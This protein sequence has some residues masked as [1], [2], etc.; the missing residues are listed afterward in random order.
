MSSSE[1]VAPG[2]RIGDYRIEGERRVEETGVI[3]DATHLVLPR[4][5]AIKVALGKSAAVQMLRE[6]CVLEALSHPGVPRV[7]ECGVLPDKRP[8]VALEAIDGASLATATKDTPIAIADLAMVMRACADILAHAHARGVVHHRLDE[9]IVILTPN[10]TSPVCVRGWGHVVAH[11]SQHAADPSSDIL[12]LGA[13][14]YR[15]LLRTPVGPG[16]SAQ[17][18][19]PEAPAD[20]TK[21]IDEMLAADP[22]RRPTAADVSERAEWIAE[23]ME[24]PR[25]R[26]STPTAGM[27]PLKRS[28]TPDVVVR[29]RG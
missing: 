1:R 8:W 18:S 2:T 19:C 15:A 29:I 11:D 6:A 27:Q 24:A 20:L 10:R 23:T 26:V 28:I 3:Y 4:H 22:K 9:S 7:Y 21:L 16:A 25:A 17:R 13:L 5:A 14:A 12:A